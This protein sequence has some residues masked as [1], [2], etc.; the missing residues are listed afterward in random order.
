MTGMVRE[1]F[2]V[3]GGRGFIGRHM[4]RLLNSMGADCLVPER[5]APA[6]LHGPLGHVIYCAGVTSDFRRR[7][8][9][10][11][12][13]H[14]GLLGEMLERAAFTSLLYLSSTRMYLGGISG[15]EETEF[16]VDPRKPDHLFHLSKLAGEA[17]CHQSGRPGVRIARLSNVCGDDYGSGNFLYSLLVDAVGK[18][19]ILLRT[20]L[21]SAK[22]YIGVDDAVRLLLRIALE[23]K[24][25]VYN[26][27]S[28]VNTTNGA[29]A[30]WIRERTGCSVQVADD[31]PDVIFPVIGIGRITKEFGYA[32]RDSRTV[33][34]GVIEDYLAKRRD[35][36]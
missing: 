8:F 22:D 7:P 13:A 32:P 18:K 9:D 1:R 5:D 20:S 14:C 36:L 30:G 15:E 4:V 35:P 34:G 16:T 29:I 25:K 27:A 2:T 17:L 24:S 10:A 12:R 28:G 3:V 23:G 33:I 26:V 21:D 6:L 31:A 19:H 11:M